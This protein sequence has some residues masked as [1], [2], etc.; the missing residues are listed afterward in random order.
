VAKEIHPRKRRSLCYAREKTATV[1]NLLPRGEAQLAAYQNPDDHPKG[2]WKATPLHAK[3]GSNS[4]EFTFKN[5]TTWAPPA[6]T[7]RRFNDESMRRMEEGDEIWFGN[8][9]FQ[10]PSRKSFLSEVKGGVTPVTIWPYDEVGHNHEAS[11]ELKEL[12][13]GGMFSNPKP[14]RLLRRMITLA[15]GPN[16][17][18][19]DFFAGS[20]TA[21]AAVMDQNA[22]D[23]GQRKWILVQLPEAFA[24]NSEAS[25]S[26]YQTIADLSRERVRRAGQRAAESANL[27]GNV[28]DVG[29]RALTVDSTNL[30]DVLRTPDEI[31]QPQ[32][33]LQTESVKPDRTNEDLLFQVMIDWGLELTMEIVL[34]VIEGHDVFVVENGALIACFDRQLNPTLARELVNHPGNLGDQSV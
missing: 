28:L 22:E 27:T 10:V 8:D 3:S 5:G 16:D 6:G 29:F 17:I 1:L 26:G 18:V 19:L 21:A 13:L 9:G 25:R 4:G 31:Q 2:P 24:E 33:E 7:Y 23:G 32:L 12:E 20:G 30:A 15:T 14:T 11:N 34:E